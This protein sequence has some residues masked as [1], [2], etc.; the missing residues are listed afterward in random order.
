M[1]ASSRR[2]TG[3]KSV[4]NFPGPCCCHRPCFEDDLAV[5]DD[6]REAFGVRMWPIES[7]HV[8]HFGRIEHSDVSLHSRTQYSAVE[9]AETL[10]RE[11]RHLARRIFERDRLTLADVNR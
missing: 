4:Q 6:V 1:I 10:C 8:A 9:Q 3:V 7:R 5:D 2:I 11:S